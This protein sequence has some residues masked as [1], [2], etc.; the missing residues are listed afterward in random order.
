MILFC[1]LTIIFE[2]LSSPNNTDTTNIVKEI[3]VLICKN[4]LGTAQNNILNT[5]SH[6]QFD[7]LPVLT[8]SLSLQNGSPQISLDYCH[9][10]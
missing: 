1:R 9:Y 2:G 4:A 8:I 10:H 6:C 3:H 7:S 5:S